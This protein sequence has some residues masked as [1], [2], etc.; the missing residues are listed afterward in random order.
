MRHG[1]NDKHINLIFQVGF[2]SYL[3]GMET[4]F[5]ISYHLRIRDSFRSYLWGMETL[6]LSFLSSFYRD[7]DPTYEAWKRAFLLD[8]VQEGCHSDPTYEAWKLI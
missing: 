5:Q 7:S 3:W 2:R 1:N 4:L 6:L 8:T